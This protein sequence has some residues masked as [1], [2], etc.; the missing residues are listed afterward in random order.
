MSHET[1]WATIQAEHEII[2]T[3][4]ALINTERDL[5]PLVDWLWDYVEEQHHY[6]EETLLFEAL[7]KYPRLR[8]GGPRC[9]YFYGMQ[10]SDPPLA[11][12]ERTTKIK[13]TWLDHQLVFQTENSPLV[14][15]I[16]EH[17]ATRLILEHARQSR[18]KL[19]QEQLR[20]LLIVYAQ[21]QNTNMDKE[22]TC[23]RHLSNSILREHDN[24]QI[25]RLWKNWS[26][27]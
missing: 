1:I 5:W 15:P 26:Q 9:I 3:K 22:E 25:I 11:L 7:R 19:N 12:A 23:L 18:E 20:N 8:E 4:L 14:I 27:T 13:S 2:R 16:S 17:R 6:Q 24:K 10:M 21:I